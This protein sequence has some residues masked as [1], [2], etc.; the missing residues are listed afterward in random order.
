MGAHACSVSF[1]ASCRKDAPGCGPAT[2]FPSP[3]TANPTAFALRPARMPDAARWK[4]AL[5]FSWVHPGDGNWMRA[6]F[7]RPC[8]GGF[9]FFPAIRWFRCAASDATALHHR[10]ISISPPGC[11]QPCQRS[12]E[13]RVQRITK[14]LNSRQSSGKPRFLSK[15]H[16]QFSQKLRPFSKKLRT[17]YKKPQLFSKDFRPFYKKFRLFPEDFRAF[18]KQPRIFSEKPKHFQEIS[19]NS[20]NSSRFFHKLLAF[21]CKTTSV[22]QTTLPLFHTITEFFRK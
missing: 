6:A 1:P 11:Q 13:E 20:N 5:P 15:K 16:R 12:D 10:L 8:R 2:A 4:R 3:R 14:N 7:R 17:F 22:Y 18:P 19:W 21:L 9:F